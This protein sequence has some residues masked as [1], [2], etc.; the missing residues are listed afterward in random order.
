MLHAV[1]YQGA[2]GHWTLRWLAGAFRIYK[3]ARRRKPG[4]HGLADAV[5]DGIEAFNV[6]IDP[7]CSRRGRNGRR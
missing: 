3:K 6:E 4:P 7:E 5:R 1:R 2:L